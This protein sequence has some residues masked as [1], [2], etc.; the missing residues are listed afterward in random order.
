MKL[1]LLTHQ[2]ELAKA[3]N[4]GSLVSDVLAEQSQVIVWQRKQPNP[5]LLAE[6][7]RGSTALLYPTADSQ[8]VTQND[9]FDNYIVLDATWQEAQKMLNQSPY[10][11]SLPKVQVSASAKSIYTLRRNQKPGGLCTAE[12]VAELL[13]A[14]GFSNTAN[15]LIEHLR[16]FMTQRHIK[17]QPNI[18]HTT[19]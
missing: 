17:H 2:R 10:L 8:V 12:C 1:F 5:A 18:S 6:I 4:T 16:C 15:T 13:K 3:T 7:D 11:Q 14:N 9:G 19:Q